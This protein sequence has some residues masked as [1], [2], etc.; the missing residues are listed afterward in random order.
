MAS[1]F[2][3]SNSQQQRDCLIAEKYKIKIFFFLSTFISIKCPFDQV[4]F[5]SSVVSI[6]C[7]F[8][9]VSFRSSVAQS[10]VVFITC[11]SIN[12]R[13]TIIFTNFFW[14]YIF[15]YKILLLLLSAFPYNHGKPQRIIF[16][17]AILPP[18]SVFF[19]TTSLISSFTTSKNL[20]FGLPLFLFPGNSISI[21]FLP[22][23]SW[24]LFMT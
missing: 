1:V 13:S 12:C 21:I 4:S 20:F 8:N 22:T 2:Y 6:Q 23:Y 9:P 10:S 7:R 16:L 14:M 19:A 18:T 5:P 3:E 11:R 15:L 24:S 17:Q